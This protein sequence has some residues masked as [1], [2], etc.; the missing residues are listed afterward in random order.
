MTKNKDHI[1]KTEKFEPNEG[2]DESNIFSYNIVAG[3]NGV[4]K[5]INLPVNKLND[6]LIKT[7]KDNVGPLDY[8]TNIKGLMTEWNISNRYIDRLHQIIKEHLPVEEGKVYDAY[9]NF[10]ETWGAIY[11]HQDFCKPHSHNPFTWSWIYYAQVDDKSS[12]LELHNLIKLTDDG[13][14][15]S[16]LRLQP[17]SG[18]LVIFPSYATHS[19][20]KTGG[21][22]EDQWRIILAGNIMTELTRKNEK[23]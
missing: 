13:T 22:G 8:K 16:N 19:V 14:E 9:Y 6:N 23:R 7:V 4:I 15:L 18:Q 21:I 12:P 3:G 11:K 10:L 1:E 17:K 2:N 20:S 5:V